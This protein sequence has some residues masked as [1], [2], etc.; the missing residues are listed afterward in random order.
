MSWA[1]YRIPV[2]ADNTLNIDNIE[3]ADRGLDERPDGMPLMNDIVTSMILSLSNTIIEFH[4]KK[5]KRV[6]YSISSYTQRH[7]GAMWL[8]DIYEHI[9]TFLDDTSGFELWIAHSP[10]DLIAIRPNPDKFIKETRPNPSY[11]HWSLRQIPRELDDNRGMVNNYY[12]ILNNYP[13]SLKK[14][15]DAPIYPCP[16][17]RTMH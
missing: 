7:D 13:V 8:P 6:N 10:T 3:V 17:C 16:I 1:I 5:P 15:G 11:I 14:K 12:N 4:R 9:K 2:N